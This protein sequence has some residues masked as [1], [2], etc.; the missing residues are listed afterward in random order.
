MCV[1]FLFL[2]RFP[3][4]SLSKTT[5]G[6][7]I[8]V[9]YNSERMN[10]IRSARTVKDIN[11]YVQGIKAEVVSISKALDVPVAKNSITISISARGTV[12]LGDI[13]AGIPTTKKQV[14]NPLTGAVDLE[15]FDASKLV[16]RAK[17][18]NNQALLTQAHQE[19]LIAYQA[20]LSKTLGGTS[21]S[22]RN[23]A[24]S[25]IKDLLAEIAQLVI[26][27]RRQA[28]VPKTE[29]PEST[30]VLAKKLYNTVKKT[31]DEGSVTRITPPEHYVA[32]HQKKI[33]G[34]SQTV[35][36]VMV[37]QSFIRLDNFTN[38]EGLVYKDYSV[39][40][41]TEINADNG[42]AHYFLTTLTNIM[43]AGSFPVGKELATQEQLVSRLNELLALDGASAFQSKRVPLTKNTQ[44]LKKLTAFGLQVHKI[45]GRD[46]TLFDNI[47]V[48]DNKLFIR[49]VVG[50]SKTEKQQAV[51]EA[52]AMFSTVFRDTVGKIKKSDV[53]YKIQQSKASGA[54]FV[55]EYLVMQ[56]V[57]SRGFK[58][59]LQMNNSIKEISRILE[60]GNDDIARL[61]QALK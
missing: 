31:V 45:R 59:G 26:K 1:L 60:L 6:Y 53:A 42:E 18:A 51:E 41:T 17:A 8:M 49:L 5:R 4:F 38:S 50:L 30:L 52:L 20:L 21:E 22:T 12:E 32:K 28:A 46:T 24:A 3:N 27:Y 39:V 43:T 40:L 47:R 14:S 29:I 55:R 7:T 44:E 19:L 16:T 61:K 9:D 34:D 54:K 23:Q 58:S 2:R 56:L 37:F 57:A 36:D 35:S 13:A 10:A 48:Q 15:S 11:S 33:D 25:A